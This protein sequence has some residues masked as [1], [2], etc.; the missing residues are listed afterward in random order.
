MA[1]DVEQKLKLIAPQVLIGAPGFAAKCEGPGKVV[2]EKSVQRNQTPI[3]AIQIAR[4]DGPFESGDYLMRLEYRT[5][6]AFRLGIRIGLPVAPWSMAYSKEKQTVPGK[7]EK[8]EFEFSISPDMAGRK[9]RFPCFDLGFA[10]AGTV[11]EW[12]PPELFRIY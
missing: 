8:Q 12:N 1:D 11:L 3:H 5:N 9:L 4:M 10:P 7:W 6:K 2:V